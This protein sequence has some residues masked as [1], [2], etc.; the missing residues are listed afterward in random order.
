MGAS[1]VSRARRP[2]VA[3]PRHPVTGKQIRVSGKSEGELAR[4]LQYVDGMRSE[5]RLGMTSADEVDRKLRRLAH[6]PVTVQRAAEAFL[7]R[8]D[9]AANT[10]RRVR[11]FLSSAGATLVSLELDALDGPTLERWEQRLRARGDARSYIV[12]AWR[13][14]RQVVGYASTRGWI[15]R[16]PWGSWHPSTRPSGKSRPEREA[17]RDPAELGAM[18]E[19]ARQL[20]AERDRKQLLP[21]LEPK[22]ATTAV[23]G[24]RQGELAGLRWSDLDEAALTVT[25]AR[26]WNGDELPKGK[27][28]KTLRA[29]RE[30]FELLL[31]WRAELE[32]RSLYHAKG[33]VFPMRESEPGHARAY[34]SGECL[35]RRDLRSVVERANLPRPSLWSPHSLRDTFVTLEAIAAHGDLRMLADRSRH[36]SIGSLV[37]YLRSRSREPAAPGFALPERAAPPALAERSSTK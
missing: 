32:A 35:S 12:A 14:L 17:A 26:Q 2:F 8:A 25:I 1:I 19:A 36:A 11:T 13:T 5:L 27:K 16:P 23:L 6:G 24:L 34:S 22:I 37:R 28:A 15:G 30:L 9:V 21:D 4:L 29:P 18:L 10:R 31:T 20:D 33:P 7:E 3:W